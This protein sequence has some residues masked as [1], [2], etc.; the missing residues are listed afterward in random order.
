MNFLLKKEKSND[1]VRNTHR[2]FLEVDEC[3]NCVTNG[4]RHPEDQYN[5]SYH[6]SAKISP[7]PIEAD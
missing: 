1:K 5:L 6:L 3:E 7:K 4:R 2:P